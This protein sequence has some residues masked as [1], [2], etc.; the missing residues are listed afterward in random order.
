MVV[1]DEDSICSLVDKTLRAEYDVT[2]AGDG[3]E[4]LAVIEAGGRFDLI[5]SDVMMPRMNGVELYRALLALERDQ[6]GK[7][8]FFTASM[9][10]PDI[11]AYLEAVP[12]AVLRKPISVPALRQFVRALIP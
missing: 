3:R 4:A 7:V 12:N 11:E 9:L 1:D 6:A 5:L 8:V 2:V 10:P